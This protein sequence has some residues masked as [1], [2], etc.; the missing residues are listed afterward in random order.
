MDAGGDKEQQNKITVV[1][2][3]PEICHCTCNV[4]H[5]R[6]KLLPSMVFVN[7]GRPSADVERVSL[8]TSE[9]PSVSTDWTELDSNL[10]LFDADEEITVLDDS[11]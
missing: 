9:T 11:M 5:L 1:H 6:S 3:K 10:T 2:C 8:N 7:T 4:T